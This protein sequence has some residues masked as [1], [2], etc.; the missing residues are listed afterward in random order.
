MSISNYIWFINYLKI[1]IGFLAHSGVE[2]ITRLPV[3]DE[4]SPVSKMYFMV[5]RLGTVDEGVFTDIANYKKDV[6]L[7]N[8]FF[9]ITWKFSFT[10]FMLFKTTLSVNKVMIIFIRTLLFPYLKIRTLFPL[11]IILQKWGICLRCILMQLH[12]T[13]L[14]GSFE[15]ILRFFFFN[16]VKYLGWVC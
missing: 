8:Y 4:K 15:E 13:S 12:C 7:E 9:N 1:F 5:L 2:V 16:K 3:P 10:N 6:S 14:S 11:F